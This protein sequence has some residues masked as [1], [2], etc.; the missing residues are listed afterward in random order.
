MGD[1][2]LVNDAFL[3]ESMRKLDGN[4]EMC[5]SP[6]SMNLVSEFGSFYIQFDRF[7]YL[8]IGCFEKA[9]LKLP[10]YPEDLL[11]FLEVCRQMVLVNVKY[12]NM[13]K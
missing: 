9:P 12:M 3:M 8:R 2:F 1:F 13:G 11:V 6:K 5:F 10:R 7:S 4:L